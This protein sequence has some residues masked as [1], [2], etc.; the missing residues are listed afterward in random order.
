MS[1]LASPVFYLLSCSDS[2]GNNENELT[3]RSGI[4]KRSGKEGDGPQEEII[5]L[6]PRKV[7]HP[8]VHFCVSHPS[9]HEIVR[10]V[11]RCTDLGHS[12]NRD[13]PRLNYMALDR[14]GQCLEENNC[15]PGSDT[16][17]VLVSH[18]FGESSCA[19]QPLS[20]SLAMLR[21]GLLT[22][23]VQHKAA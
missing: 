15:E 1:P 18:H 2:I 3:R 12:Y 16:V 11:Y 4:T 13:A 10:L 20:L 6:L 14:L 5:R 22:D 17:I 9:A 7:S 8:I 23:F 19:A 21:N